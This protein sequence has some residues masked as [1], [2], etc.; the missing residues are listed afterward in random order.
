MQ[1]TSILQS[2]EQELAP[3][4]APLGTDSGPMPAPPSSQSLPCHPNLLA[5]SVVDVVVEPA[6]H[7][8]ELHLSFK[9][10]ERGGI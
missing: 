9:A 8:L 10:Q 3:L 6:A 4:R 5:L 2:F 1:R 7:A